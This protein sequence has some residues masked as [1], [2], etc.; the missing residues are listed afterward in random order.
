MNSKI[1]VLAG[2]GIGPEI[3]ESGLKVLAAVEK[4][5]SS[6][7]ELEE[8]PFGGAGIDDTGA[9]LPEKTLAACQ[10]ADA[11]LLGAI[12]GPKW[13]K[14]DDT[15]E[16]GLLALRK[17]LNL[18]A[19]IRPVSVSSALLHLSPL[20]P[21][22]IEGTDLIIVR[23]LSSGIYFGE[24][25]ELQETMAYDTAR[26]QKSEIERIVHSAFKIAQGRGK[27]VTSVDKA[28]VLA[29]SKLWRATANEVAKDYPDCQL[30]HQYVD[31]AAMKLI[32]NPKAFDVIV[33]EN[34]FGDI[35]SD[36]ASVLPGSLGVLPSASHS[37]G[38]P[39]LYE[40]IHGSAPDIAGKGIAN[41]ISM[42]LSV[43]MMLRQ[44]FQEEQ[45]AQAIEKACDAVLSKGLFTHDLGGKAKTTEFTDAVIQELTDP[46]SC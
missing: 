1:V 5:C 23:E 32:Q 24:P 45:A 39:S 2:D 6:T 12:G 41:P 21:E 17:S 3:M 8:M 18:F 19:N 10:K 11:I 16:K 44:S 43:A 40:P 4:N 38:G 25:R 34:L 31:S 46:V 13:E 15:P 29:S 42:I 9:S 7:F 27:K 33:T 22:I 20:K 36:E 26:Y 14:M 37:D 28:N 35:L 30:E